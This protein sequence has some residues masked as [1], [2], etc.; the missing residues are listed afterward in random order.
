M[1]GLA[2]WGLWQTSEIEEKFKKNEIFSRE[3]VIFAAKMQF[4]PHERGEKKGC[5]PFFKF[6]V[7]A[8]VG[9]RRGENE[10][11]PPGVCA[12]I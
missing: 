10:I 2:G 11:L 5:N 7:A 6:H 1:L 8:R 4:S 9:G 12:E 3:N